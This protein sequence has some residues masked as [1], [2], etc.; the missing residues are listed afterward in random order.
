M[1]IDKE[2]FKRAK[3]KPSKAEDWGIVKRESEESDLG[4]GGDH[5]EAGGEERRERE[6]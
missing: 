6:R 3:G 1:G 4:R 2:G 5:A